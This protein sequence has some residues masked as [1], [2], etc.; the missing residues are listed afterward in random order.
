MSIIMLQAYHRIRTLPQTLVDCV[1]DYR[2]MR[3]QNILIHKIFKMCFFV[4]YHV[5]PSI[6]ILYLAEKLAGSY[7]FLN[8]RSSNS[9]HQFI[10]VCRVI[11]RITKIALNNFQSD[12]FACAQQYCVVLPITGLLQLNSIYPY[13][14]FFTALLPSASPGRL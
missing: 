13:F 6:F 4:Y 3:R 9:V 11:S 7:M 2:A 12:N 5:S 8:I 1:R 10:N 14:A